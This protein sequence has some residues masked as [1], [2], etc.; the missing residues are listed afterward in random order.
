MDIQIVNDPIFIRG[1]IGIFIVA[2]MMTIF[3]LVLYYGFA[4]PKFKNSIIT[5]L[6]DIGIFDSK[7]IFTENNTVLNIL[8]GVS[9]N[10]ENS[11]NYTN[12]L[13]A[14]IMSCIIIMLFFMLIFM[15][16]KL[17]TITKNDIFGKDIVPVVLNSLAIFVIL[18]IFQI[19]VLFY[20]M[21]YNYGSQ[22]EIELRFVNS[23]LKARNEEIIDLPS[24]TNIFL[25]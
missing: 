2:I 20:S 23:L 25:A 7:N 24:G 4:W 19:L 17:E 22:D 8:K 1:V 13:K 12:S 18:I 5:Q 11:D 21:D 3:E 9:K 6:N 10:D 15:W 16:V 14:G